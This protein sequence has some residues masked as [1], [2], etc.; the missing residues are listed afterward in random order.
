MYKTPEANLDTSLPSEIKK[1]YS[2]NQVA[3]G[4]I[5]GPIGIIYFLASNFS[6]LGKEREKQKT[7]VIGSLFIALLIGLMPF[8]PDEMPGS[9]FT[10]AYVVIARTISVKYQMTKESII[11]SERHDFYSNW[12]VFG[13]GLVCLVVSF[14]VLM[15]PYLI[16]DLMGV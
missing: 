14:V 12:R 9:V 2:P 8:I 1:L 3:C 13:M 7:L 11:N 4:T 16:L 10:I 5:G 6:A 15:A